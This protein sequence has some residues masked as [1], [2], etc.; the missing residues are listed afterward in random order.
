MSSDSQSFPTNA[1]LENQRG[2]SYSETAAPR[3]GD[4]IAVRD[5]PAVVQAADVRAL[6]NVSP[7][8]GQNADAQRDFIGGYLGADDRARHA[9]SASLRSLAQNERGGAFFLNG[10]FGSGKS[11][12]LGVLALLAD[13]IG[14]ANFLETHPEFAP[15]LAPFAPR[16]VIHFSLDE[17]DAARFSLEE[18][19]WREARAEWL[20]R[21]YDE[22]H[23][24]LPDN[25]SRVEMMLALENALAAKQQRGLVICIDELSLFLSAREHRAL[26]GDA[27]FLQFL[28]QHAR[29]GP[30][31][32]FAALQKTM[33]DVGELEAYSL[34]QIRDRF[35][36]L[37][38]S[39]AHLPSLIERRLIARRDGEMLRQICRDSWEKLSRALPRLDFGPTEWEALYPFHPPT[40]SLLEGATAR[41]FSRTRSAML[42]CAGAVD[43]EAEAATRVL[44][45]QLFAYLAPEL[46]EHPDL[47][48]L[49][50]VWRDWQALLP[51]LGLDARDL[52]ALQRL[53]QTLLLF[54]IAGHAP[55]LTQLANAASM[56]AG[57]PGDG[58]YDW[59]RAL[60]ERLRTRGS[61]LAIERADGEANA[62][63]DRYTIDFGLRV[64]EAARRHTRGMM[65]SLPVGDAR[66]A[67]F[68]LSCCRSSDLP[69]ASLDV[70]STCAVLWRNAPRQF[71]LKLLGG[72]TAPGLV[73]SVMALGKPGHETDALLLIAP[74]FD[75]HS[76]AAALLDEVRRTLEEVQESDTARWKSALLLWTPRRP[77]QDEWELAREATAHHLL[78]G[79]P[80]L[81]DNRRGR[82][83]LAHVKNGAPQRES[84][85]SKLAA[86]LL[87]EG[88]IATAAGQAGEAGEL[89]SGDG[90]A[91][92]LESLAEFALPFVFPKF[93]E[94][95]PRLRVLTPSNTEALCLD[96][97]RRPQ[98]APYFAASLERAARALAEPLGVARAEAGRW[99]IVAP[100]SALSEVINA[101]CAEGATLSHLESVLCKSEWGLCAEQTHLLVCGLLRGGQLAAMDTRGQ[102]I[103]A[104]QIGMPL[105]RS[106]RALR[107][108]RLL[109]AELWPRL[110][111]L[112][113]LL[114]NEQLGPLSFAEQ[115][116]A[117]ALLTKWREEALADTE[118]AQARLH[119]LRRV[120]NT[121]MAEWP[122]TRAVWEEIEALLAATASG[123]D[124]TGLLERVAEL[125][126]EML[127]PAL[128]F[129]RQTLRTLDEKHAA[130]LEAHTSLTHPA[131]SV[132]PALQESRA[133]LLVRFDGGETMLQDENLLSDTL[134]W[135]N[136]YVAAYREWHET[137]HAPARFLPYRALLAGDTLRV[138]D[139]LNM[140]TARTFPQAR[141]LRAAATEEFA[142]HCSRDA[143]LPPGEA[144]CP[145]C[146]L[147][148]SERLALRDP[149]E[150][151]A[152]GDQVLASLRL[153]LRET[154]VAATL[155]AQPSGEALL[156]WN[157][158][159]DAE[160]EA[161]L[162]LL[163]DAALRLLDEALRPH[164]QTQR[165]LAAL[166]EKFA[167]CRTRR[168]FLE[169]FTH[170]LD[171]GEHLNDNDHVILT[172]AEPSQEN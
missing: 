161:L 151:A 114:T 162:P 148:W 30:L 57:L 111:R 165:S 70:N 83:I 168:D 137:Q 86:R 34:A 73:N 15:I 35:T 65:D 13:G 64:S 159:G 36:L 59:S 77:T 8:N 32:V 87:R 169:A 105:R 122:Q 93:A 40:V 2:T 130:I 104:A 6:R 31:C 48:P 101:I 124:G 44:P 61:C 146:R 144:V 63:S 60:L 56:D 58:N 42:F 84:A 126:L 170:W 10:V 29:R 54:K 74:P 11:H 106:V 90:W 39:L 107:P 154:S 118:L 62:F 3:V 24:N 129:W 141:A 50:G 22:H 132:P 147:R 140:L 1:P 150:I 43:V 5:F 121:T 18:I 89:L 37:P 91:Q 79:D 41:F 117:C 82:A 4:L 20:R 16:L 14:H 7:E 46:E 26:Q 155:A 17:Y 142:K 47:R 171:A 123:S 96:I 158:R 45:D 69:L 38:L 139:R 94:V 72:L 163:S 138:L 76:G 75:D 19:F 134:S 103:S 172:K 92:T 112:A 128:E 145:Q 52:A 127:S 109:D 102:S 153:A 166:E 110:R 149:R 97:L 119:Q 71:A 25:A 49:A 160:S 125:D 51:A 99:R 116:H 133:A 68:A 100:Q 78:E 66:I 28:G 136:S 98:D 156:Q 85:L 80:Q 131:L 120:C 88:Q 53:M 152:I 108:G 55:T 23:W 67:Q 81:L 27:A 95:A 113:A 33:E 157:E 135:R 164:R 167:S 143:A 21:G 115:E 9:L 12:L